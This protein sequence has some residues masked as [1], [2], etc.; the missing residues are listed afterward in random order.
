M[1]AANSVREGHDFSR[2]VIWILGGAALQ[3]CDSVLVSELALAV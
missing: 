1:R 2:A 3:R